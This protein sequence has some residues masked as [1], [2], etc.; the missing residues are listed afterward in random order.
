[1][2]RRVRFAWPTHRRNVAAEVEADRRSKC[3]GTLQ[4]QLPEAAVTKREAFAFEFDLN[5]DEY[6][7]IYSL[8][9]LE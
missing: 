6:W 1:M 9:S 8:V 4:K 5:Y 3:E 2:E 7:L